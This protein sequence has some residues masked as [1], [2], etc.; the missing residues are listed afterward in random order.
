MGCSATERSGRW[1][2]VF[3]GCMSQGASS[4]EC[5]THS[6]RDLLS[7]VLRASLASGSDSPRW[8]AKVSKGPR[9]TSQ[10]REL[11]KSS[12]ERTGVEEVRAPCDPAKSVAGKSVGPEG[13]ARTKRR[14][15]QSDPQ[16]EKRTP[17]TGVI[18]L[19]GSKGPYHWGSHTKVELLPLGS[20]EAT[21]LASLRG[22]IRCSG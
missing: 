18:C 17:N 11:E 16:R 4:S 3:A 13:A 8:I 12:R 2:V 5:V 6:P 14:E 21:V 22:L 20:M 9:A 15:V 1:R 10:P 7:P 19:G